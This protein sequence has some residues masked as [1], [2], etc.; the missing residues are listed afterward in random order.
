MTWLQYGISFRAVSESVTLLMISNA[1]GGYGNDFAV[2]DIGFRVCIP[3]VSSS[4]PS[5]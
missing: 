1:P 2:D 5:G 3:A 4:A